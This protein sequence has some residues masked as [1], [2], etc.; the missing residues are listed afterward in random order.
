M[1]NQSY[2]VCPTCQGHG[3]HVHPYLSVWTSDRIE[4]DPEGFHEMARGVYDV[5]CEECGGKRVTTLAEH[6][7]WLTT[8]EDMKLAMMENG[9]VDGLMGRSW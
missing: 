5:L 6:E 1:S 2:I 9:D 8:K 3:T 4:E 7:V